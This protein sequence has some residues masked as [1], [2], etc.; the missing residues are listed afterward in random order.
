MVSLLPCLPQ[1]GASVIWEATVYS[2]SDLECRVSS[3][4]QGGGG[5]SRA[6]GVHQAQHLQ[7]EKEER[8]ASRKILPNSQSNCCLLGN[9]AAAWGPWTPASF[10]GLGRR[11]TAGRGFPTLL[12][13][14]AGGSVFKSLLSRLDCFPL[15]SEL[16]SYFPAPCPGRKWRASP[17]EAWWEVPSIGPALQAGYPPSR[18]SSPLGLSS[19]R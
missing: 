9:E 1:A 13:H 2:P 19:R 4:G 7:T 5:G 10:L 18:F 8:K 3:W 17:W 11:G 16:S 6:S 12:W 15:V 14:L